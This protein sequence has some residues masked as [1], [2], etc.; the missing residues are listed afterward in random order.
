MDTTESGRLRIILIRGRCAKL[1][2]VIAGNGLEHGADDQQ[3]PQAE[4]ER[5][6]ASF[7]LAA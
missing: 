5:E 2:S 6:T 7:P 1:A 4:Q 3:R